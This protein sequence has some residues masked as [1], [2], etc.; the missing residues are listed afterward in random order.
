MDLLKAIINGARNDWAAMAWPE[1]MIVVF[2]AIAI[3][4][5]LFV[6]IAIVEATS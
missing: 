2:M 3:C 5:A 4:F 6:L 1:R